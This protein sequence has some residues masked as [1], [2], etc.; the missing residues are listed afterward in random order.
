M[1]AM[2]LAALDRK[3]DVKLGQALARLNEEDP[4]FTIV[5]NAQTH[6]TV[7]WGQGE[8]HLRVALD[9]LKR[10][11]GVSVNSRAAADGAYRETIRSS[12]T[13]ERGKHKKQSGGHGQFGDVVIEVRLPAVASRHRHGV[14]PEDHGGVVPKNYFG[15]VEEGV[16]DALQKGPLGFPVVD[17]EATLL[18][19]SY[20]TVDF[21]RSCFPHR[22]A[23]CGVSQALPECNPV[24]LEPVHMVPIVCTHRHDQMARITALLTD[25]VAARPRLRDPRPDWLGGTRIRAY[26]AG[27]RAPRPDHRD[28]LG[29]RRGL[30]ELQFAFDHMA[31]V[32]GR[33]AEQ[34]IA[35]HRDAA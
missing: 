12:S 26:A 4:S 28:P 32:T 23:P 10:S 11:F 21:A 33:A 30:G 20:H 19:G 1:L 9:R 31:E 17:V 24:L 29:E 18:D 35:A 13:C 3:D 34:I 25:A 7:L 14:R 27:G 2:A 22:R 5:H 16:S 8:M 6:D 15:A